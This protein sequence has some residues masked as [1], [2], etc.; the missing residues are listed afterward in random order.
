ML[1]GYITFDAFNKTRNLY[2]EFKKVTRQGL[3]KQLIKYINAAHA[4]GGMLE[5][6]LAEGTKI[7]KPLLEAAEKGILKITLFKDM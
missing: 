6:C 5:L 1:E 2:I 7:S 3:T 4:L